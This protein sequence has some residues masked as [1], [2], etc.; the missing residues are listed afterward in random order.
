[1]IRTVEVRERVRVTVDE[2]KFTPQFME[3][4]RRVFY[5]FDSIEDHV[6]HIAQAYARGL[7]NTSRD[8]LEGY[9]PLDQFGVVLAR[10]G[11]PEIEIINS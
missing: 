9:G 11:G 7:I 3:S 10:D 6:K 1:M 5:D 8:F 2:S 4:F